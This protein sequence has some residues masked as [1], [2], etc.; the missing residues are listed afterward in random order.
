MVLPPNTSSLLWQGPCIG[1][2]EGPAISL[3]SASAKFHCLGKLPNTCII[4]ECGER[5]ILSGACIGIVKPST[6]LE[7]Q[8]PAPSCTF[9]MRVWCKLHNLFISRQPH[10]DCWYPVETR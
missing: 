6:G 7:K 10:L 4:K 3:S 2:V 8:L 9:P 1:A 5:Q